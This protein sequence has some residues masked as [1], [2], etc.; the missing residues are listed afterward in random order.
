MK[1]ENVKWFMVHNNC[2]YLAMGYDDNG[3]LCNGPEGFKN[4]GS[5][6]YMTPYEAAV[7]FELELAKSNK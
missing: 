4:V 6:L 7:H 3:R 2:I 1:Y 5:N